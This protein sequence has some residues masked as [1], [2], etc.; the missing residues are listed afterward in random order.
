[1]YG[2][3][4]G[5]SSHTTLVVWLLGRGRRGKLRQEQREYP[6]GYLF[7]IVR[8]FTF[9]YWIWFPKPCYFIYTVKIGPLGL[10]C[11]SQWGAK[12]FTI[13]ACVCACGCGIRE[14]QQALCT[15]CSTPLPTVFAPLPLCN[16]VHWL[17][18]RKALCGMLLCHSLQTYFLGRTRK[19]K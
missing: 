18:T 16:H 8:R 4:K 15:R 12:C 17:E 2:W 10:G 5:A 1:M 14:K 11:Q 13:C 19:E 9:T 3:G 6:A 7:L